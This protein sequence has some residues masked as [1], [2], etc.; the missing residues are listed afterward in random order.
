MGNVVLFVVAQIGVVVMLRPDFLIRA[1]EWAF[2]GLTNPN[3]L[4][5]LFLG[6]NWGDIRVAAV[7]AN[8]LQ[9]DVVAA[10]PVQASY[11]LF[12]GPNPTKFAFPLIE[13]GPRLIQEP[14]VISWCTSFHDGT[15]V[16]DDWLYEGPAVLSERPLTSAELELIRARDERKG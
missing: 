13:P 2:P 6:G 1:V 7:A 3:S 10:S 4:Y 9:P 8:R 5:R 14:V 11:K 16:W 12:N 15:T